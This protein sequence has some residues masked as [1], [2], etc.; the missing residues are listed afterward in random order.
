MF[1]LFLSSFGCEARGESTSVYIIRGG[2]GYFPNLGNIVNKN[3]KSRGLNVID[4][5]VDQHTKAAGE[6]IAAHRAGK[7]SSGVFLVGYSAGGGAA[8]KIA[9][10]LKSAGVSVRLLI[11]IETIRPDLAIPSNVQGCFNLYHAPHAIVGRVRASSSK[12]RLCNCD[13]H[14]DAG[15]GP[16][17]GHFRIPWVDG[18]HEMI[19]DE[20]VNATRGRSPGATLSNRRALNSATPSPEPR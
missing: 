1:A 14:D 10:S 8:I 3:F 17:Y 2:G 15:F 13:A 11:L 6:I 9:N 7:L 19:A 16:E 12:T 20:I 4:Y 5:R 18:V